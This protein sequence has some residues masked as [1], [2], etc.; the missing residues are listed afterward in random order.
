MQSQTCN[1]NGKFDLEEMVKSSQA[2]GATIIEML[3]D[4]QAH[5]SYLPE[6]A[7]RQLADLSGVPLA[8]IM[9]IATFYKAFTLQ[10]RGRCPLNICLGTACHVSGA[11]RILERLEAELG[12]VAGE[13][14][15]PD[16][17]FSID[18]VRC[19]GAC[20]LAPVIVAG[21]RTFGNVTVT[22]VPDILDELRKE[23][24]SSGTVSNQ[25]STV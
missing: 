10:P 23:Y 19:V 12:I 24:Q 15:T 7:L 22:D 8:R 21:D 25:V 9:S 14:A 11:P 6:D 1:C 4:I 13:G 3:Q 16:G 2:S 18:T 5:R 20:S 17:L